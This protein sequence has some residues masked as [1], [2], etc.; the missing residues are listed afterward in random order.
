M[1]LSS[2]LRGDSRP[3]KT[4]SDGS[5]SNHASRP[6][7][8]VATLFM[9]A[10]CS[11]VSAPRIEGPYKAPSQ[12]SPVNSA[13]SAER[14]EAA[15]LVGRPLY[16]TPS[17][18]DII[19]L[20]SDL[21]A[22][23]ADLAKNPDDPEKLIWVGRRLG[24]L[25]RMNDAIA[26]FTRGI[27][28]HPQYAALYRHRGHRYLSVRQFELAIRDFEK[29]A[30]LLGSQ[31]DA[32]EPDGMPNARNIPLTTTA[33]NIWYHLGVARYLT[34]DYEAALRAFAET[35]KHTRGLDDNLVAFS[36]WMYLT[37]RR[38]GRHE[39]AAALLAPIRPNMEI[40]ENQAYH[41]RLLMYKGVLDPADVLKGQPTGTLD[42]ATLGY[43]VG[44]W[45]LHTGQTE[46]A[47]R[48]FEQ[49]EQGPYWPA[50]GHLAAEVELA[51]HKARTQRLSIT[52]SEERW[53]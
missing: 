9:L 8:V 28:K 27:E 11:C 42:Y 16:A 43:G 14:P 13:L 48:L 35:M 4:E 29:A 46:T 53:R 17:G 18:A 47:M 7:K 36:D 25:W 21:A 45:Y 50:F 41:K 49:I 51:R 3:V 26:V 24:Y 32:I 10:L 39:D 31:P 19:K 23:E 1:G 30:Q 20:K 12:G 2:M 6:C 37:L 44:Y 52:R 33:F 40:M 15:S 34:E 5:F 38:L 22:A